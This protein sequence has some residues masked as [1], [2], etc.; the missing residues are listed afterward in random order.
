MNLVEEV[1][2]KLKEDKTKLDVLC[3]SL[4]LLG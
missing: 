1:R 4:A 3:V 2:K